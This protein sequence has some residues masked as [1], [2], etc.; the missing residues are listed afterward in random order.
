[1]SRGGAARWG[2]HRQHPLKGAEH[3][4]AKL[5][6]PDKVA[7]MDP[8]APAIENAPLA[9]INAALQRIKAVRGS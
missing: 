2:V 9:K 5:N 7:D 6:A 4:K 8:A 1:M 3:E